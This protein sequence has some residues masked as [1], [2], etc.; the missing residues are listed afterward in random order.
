[1]LDCTWSDCVNLSTINPIKILMLLRL[2]GCDGWEDD[3]GREVFQIPVSNLKESKCCIF[4][5]NK[6]EKSKKAY[7]KLNFNKYK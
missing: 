4:D 3:I 2:M 5:D 7:T 1:M 6:S